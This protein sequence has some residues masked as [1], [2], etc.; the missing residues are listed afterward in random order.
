MAVKTD[1]RCFCNSKFKALDGFGES[2][3]VSAKPVLVFL[4]GAKVN[5]KVWLLVNMLDD[6]D[7]MIIGGEGQRCH[8]GWHPAV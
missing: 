5:D 7:E 2:L 6:G 3:G 4:N 8:G 1:V